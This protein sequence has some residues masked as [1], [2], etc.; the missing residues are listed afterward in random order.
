MFVTLFV[1]YSRH[2]PQPFEGIATAATFETRW[3]RETERKKPHWKKSAL[4]QVSFPS[5]PF[6]LQD[7]GSRP[8]PIEEKVETNATVREGVG[9][10]LADGPA[11]Q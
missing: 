8:K 10:Q 11:P 4:P 2:T 6:V 9:S 3:P 5:V 7:D 1:G